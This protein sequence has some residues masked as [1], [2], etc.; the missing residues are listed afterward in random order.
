MCVDGAHFHLASHTFHWKCRGFCFVGTHWVLTSGVFLKAVWSLSLFT[1]QIFFLFNSKVEDAFYKGELRLNGEKLWK[2]S[3]TVSHPA[4]NGSHMVL[5]VALLVSAPNSPLGPGAL[6]EG[7]HPGHAD[8]IVCGPPSL[9]SLRD[10]MSR[11]NWNKLVLAPWS[12][13]GRLQRKV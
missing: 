13:G 5:P 8:G 2:K 1:F 4:C 7:F 11:K 6:S 12:H 3:R 9:L 10:L